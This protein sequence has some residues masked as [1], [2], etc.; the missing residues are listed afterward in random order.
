MKNIFICIFIGLLIICFTLGS[1]PNDCNGHGVCKNDVC[2]CDA[3]TRTSVNLV[4]TSSG[5]LKKYTGNDCSISIF[6]N[7]IYNT[8]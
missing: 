3:Y 7:L 8:N 1:C 6:L 2:D 4:G 5:D